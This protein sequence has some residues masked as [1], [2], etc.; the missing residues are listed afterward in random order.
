[1]KALVLCGGFGTRLGT[2]TATTPKPLLEAGGKPLLGWILEHLATQGVTD[3]LVNLHFH[4]DA[5]RDTIGDGS[6]FG[7]RVRYVEEPALLGTAGTVRANADFL[8]SSGPFLVHYGDVVHDGDLRAVLT[9]HVDRDA[10]ATLAL[11]RRAGSNS[12]VQLD[13]HGL[14]RAFVERP[15]E[16]ERARLTGD[17]VFSGICVLS[18]E[19]VS[20]IPSGPCDL[21]RDVF[22]KLVH[23]H[24]IAAHE[25]GGFRIAVDSPERLA[26]LDLALR[27]G[28]C[29]PGRIPP[30]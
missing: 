14:V 23:S 11:H 4:G 3:A 15:T 5:I 27:G 12:N 13:E 16:A 29:R 21:P 1:M 20:A 28:H 30:T 17:L 18:P 22:T 9:A 10:L 19:A 25:L 7:L 8:G 26:R 24:R 6:R 2:L